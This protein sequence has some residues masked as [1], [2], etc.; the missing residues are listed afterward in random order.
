MNNLEITIK[1]VAQ[2]VRTGNTR[3]VLE[4]SVVLDGAGPVGLYVPNSLENAILTLQ[5][6]NFFDH[7]N[8]QICLAEKGTRFRIFYENLLDCGLPATHWQIV[9]RL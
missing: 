1:R 8:A 4:G 9:N 6:E 3:F 2:F 5:A 7:V